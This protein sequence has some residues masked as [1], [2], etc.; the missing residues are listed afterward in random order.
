MNPPTGISLLLLL[1]LFV[2]SPAP[3]AA[4]LAQHPSPYIRMHAHDAVHWRVWEPAVLQQ[5]RDENKLIFFSVG[6]F[7]CH[8]CHVMREQS[9]NNDDVAKIINARYIP[10]KVDRELNPA[11]DDYLMNFVQLTRGFGGWP[12]NV[13]VTPQGYPLVGMVYLPQ[14]EFLQL[15]QQ[16]DTDWKTSNRQL[17]DLAQNAFEFSNR[18]YN[19]RVPMPS[20]DKLVDA[21]LT[22]TR[23]SADE[24]A[25]GIGDQAKFPQP[26]LLLALLDFYQDR[27]LPWLGEF[28]QLTLQQMA[29]QGLHDVIGGGFFRY[30]IDPA[31]HTPHYE[32]MLYTNAGLVRVYSRAYQ[33]F[34][35]ARYLQIAME[36]MDFMMREMWSP[37]GFISSLSAED[38]TGDEGGAYL[39]QPEEMQQA[40]TA[41]Q[42]K[43]VNQAWKFI[44]VTDGHGLLPAGL[45]LSD[46]WRDIKQTLLAKRRRQGTPP[47]DKVLMSWNGYALT[48]L[49]ELVRL[50]KRDDFSRRGEQLFDL[51]QQQLARG[52]V[53]KTA[54]TERRFLEDYAFVVQGML[55]W[56]AVSKRTFAD[57]GRKLSLAAVDMFW[58]GQGWRLSDQV[59]LPMPAD[60]WNIADAQLPSAEVVML[61]LIRRL[62]LDQHEQ[63]KNLLREFNRQVDARMP[64][65][66][67]AYASHISYLNQRS[68]RTM[69]E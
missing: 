15:L 21:L 12:L 42:W 22:A 66:P 8:W 10:V 17:Q 41:V 53:R 16:L 64:G 43:K 30:T 34:D 20:T 7:A 1:S 24:L 31:W 55:D 4:S 60:P 27:H 3:A 39:W 49:A 56:A 13:F 29:Q 57:T 65:N 52:L 32:K 48:A 46:D 23:E 35:D 18:I 50:G 40:L 11:L 26:A 2:P 58:G 69:P 28:L 9:F 63:A 14:P 19:K 62:E 59:I 5:A 68:K 33:V 45:A 37:R 38:G 47:D 54:T 6:Y 67:T 44:R 61:K 36:T 25:G 51:L